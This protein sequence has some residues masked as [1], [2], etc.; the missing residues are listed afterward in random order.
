MN[1]T[2]V[3]VGLSWV[4]LRSPSSELLFGSSGLSFNVVLNLYLGVGK[5]HTPQPDFIGH[6][7]YPERCDVLF[8]G[9]LSVWYKKIITGR[10]WLAETTD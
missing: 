10:K 1:R 6:L 2:S 5:Y 3:G 9:I 8:E 4:T 7:R